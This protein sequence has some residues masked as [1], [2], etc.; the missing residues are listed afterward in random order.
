MDG[1]SE[2]PLDLPPYPELAVII[3]VET[4]CVSTLALLSALR[5][6][7]IPVVMIDCKSRDGS[8]EWFRS[9]QRHYTFVLMSAPRRPHG[10]ALDSI[11]QSAQAERILLIDSDVEVL[12]A[13]MFELMRIRLRDQAVYAAGY[14]QPGQWFQTHYGTDEPL[15]P[16]I[17]FYQSRPWI[18]FAMFRVEPVRLALAVG[19]SFQ[20]S[21]VLNDIPQLQIASRLLWRRF[22]RSIFRHWRLRALDLFRREYEGCKPSYVFCDTGAQIHDVLSKMGLSFGDVGAAVPYWSIRHFQGVTRNLV[23]GHSQDAQSAAAVEPEV[24]KRLEEYGLNDSD[25][26]PSGG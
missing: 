6:I 3:N 8:F 9:L 18:P 5:Y 20:H 13:E 24:L 7:K 16:G 26:L 14:F 10:K 17:G 11:F 15:S 19:A 12:S 25:L 22:R 1:A 4:K 21:L 23:H 2:T